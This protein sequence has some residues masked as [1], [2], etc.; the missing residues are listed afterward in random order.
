LLLLLQLLLLLLLLLLDWPL[1][2]LTMTW[3]NHGHV[4]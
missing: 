4:L 1:W 2:W 3:I